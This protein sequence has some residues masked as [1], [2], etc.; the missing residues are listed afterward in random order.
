MFVGPEV[1][2]WLLD[3]FRIIWD[4]NQVP[5]DCLEGRILPL[6]KENGSKSDYTTYHGITLLFIS[7]KI[8]ANVLLSIRKDRLVLGERLEQ[9]GFTPNTSTH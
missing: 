4:L 3:I 7:A 8:F 6:W 5:E 9:S 2:Q 1:A